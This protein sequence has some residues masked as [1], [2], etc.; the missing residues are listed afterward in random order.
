MLSV[1]LSVME[2]TI[3]SCAFFRDFK[4]TFHYLY[5]HL[6]MDQISHAGLVHQLHVLSLCELN[7]E[8]NRGLSQVHLKKVVK[9]GY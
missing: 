9:W 3:F 8:L 2:P 5:L 4:Y 6:R 1:M 7:S